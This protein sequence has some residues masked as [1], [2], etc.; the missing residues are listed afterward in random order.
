MYIDTNYHL[1]W[2]KAL[3]LP[4]RCVN[5]SQPL[6]GEEMQEYIEIRGARG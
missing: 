1:G 3:L 2:V 6:R 4:A 5:S